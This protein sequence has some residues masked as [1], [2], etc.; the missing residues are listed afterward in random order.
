MISRD[1]ASAAGMMSRRMSIGRGSVFAANS[2]PILLA[3]RLPANPLVRHLHRSRFQIGGCG[4]PFDESVWMRTLGVDAF[5]RR[6]LWR[7]ARRERRAP[8]ANVGKQF[9]RFRQV[10]SENADGVFRPRHAEF[11]N[12]VFVRRLHVMA[13]AGIAQTCDDFADGESDRRRAKPARFSLCAG[14]R[15]ADGRAILRAR[16]R[17]RTRYTSCGCWSIPSRR[18]GNISL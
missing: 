4:I 11:E 17:C 2:D 6:H 14:A 9:F 7:W 15:R 1:A 3:D 12:E 5:P 8:L 13:N 16:V 18:L 10:G